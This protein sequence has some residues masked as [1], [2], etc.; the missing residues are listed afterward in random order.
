M[1]ASRV[2]SGAAHGALTRRGALALAGGGVALAALGGC[3]DDAPW[4]AVAVNGALP[5]LAFAMTRADDGRAASQADYAGRPVMLFFGYT[6]CPDV[7]PLTMGNVMQVLD[8]MGD[9]GR[10]IAV[11]FVT[12]DPVRDTL[13]V[14]KDYAAAL[15]PRVDALR[16][17]DNQLAMLAR[18]YR[19]TYKVIP[20][21]ATQPYTVLHGPSIYVFDR[22]GTARL[23]V[24]KFYDDTAD[25]AGVAA[26]MTR[27]AQEAG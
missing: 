1:A 10:D 20:A 15:D 21:T 19:V 22:R 11:L 24:P 7:C 25:I 27:L 2:G 8:T 9:A 16:G 6:H 13:P 17:T 23:M 26:D 18:R 12:V 3:R 4:H 5:S 14:L